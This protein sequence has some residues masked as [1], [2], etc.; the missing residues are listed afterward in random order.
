MQYN[1][2][3]PFIPSPATQIITGPSLPGP[4]GPAGPAGPEGLPGPV[5]PQGEQGEVGPAGPQGE[6]GDAGPVGPIGPAGP[7]QEA[8]VFKTISVSSDYTC[9]K[10]DGYI[11]V[12]NSKSEPITVKLPLTF[13]EGRVIIIKSEMNTNV[14]NR[15][16]VIVPDEGHQI[17]G[18]SKFTITSAYGNVKLLHRGGNWYVL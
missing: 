7:L 10:D 6:K 8:L 4:E 18:S 12:Q 5:G 1:W 11:G 17:D 2:N 9:S 3:M 16:V 14:P 15:K 13:D